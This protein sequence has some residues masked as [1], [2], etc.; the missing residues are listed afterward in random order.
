MAGIFPATMHPYRSD[1]GH[2]TPCIVAGTI[3]ATMYIID[4][5]GPA[6]VV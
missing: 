4:L 5:A 3:P 1:D 6:G 2:E